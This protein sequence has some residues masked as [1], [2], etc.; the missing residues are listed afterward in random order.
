MHQFDLTLKTILTRD[1]GI[2]P[3]SLTGMEV[4]RW[5]NTE[6]PEVRSRLADLLAETHDGTLFHIELQS[7]NDPRM[8]DRM[9][10]YKV[11]INRAFD[12]YPR[13][14]VLYVGQPPLRMEGTVEVPDLSF[15]CR[16]MDIRELDS[17]PLLESASLDDNILSVLTRGG[18]EVAAI[19]R[20][21]DRIAAAEPSRRKDAITEL[22]ILAGLRSLGHVIKEETER[23]PITTDIMEHDLLGPIM[24][25]AKAA[26]LVEGRLEGERTLIQNQIRKRFGPAP[27]WAVRRIESMPAQELDL[28][29][30]RLL[31]S[32]SLEDLFGH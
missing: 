21:L 3:A 10:D 2:F 31:D 25:S 5:H 11:G 24:K 28:L 1:T 27:A 15:R 30:L 17:E 26:G 4:A 32:P 9:L 29:A 14:M 13:Q 12:R 7:T 8:A 23:M 6:L 16:I 19:R 18:G 22:T 20:I